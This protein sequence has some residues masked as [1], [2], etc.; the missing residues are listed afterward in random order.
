MKAFI[1]VL[2]PQGR[3]HRIFLQG[4]QFTPHTTFAWLQGPVIPVR[5]HLH[6]IMIHLFLHFR[7]GKNR[8]M[9]FNLHPGTMEH[10][11]NAG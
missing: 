7:A 10:F 4:A 3:P 5:P 2:L 8:A 11:Y 1:S 9:S 6:P